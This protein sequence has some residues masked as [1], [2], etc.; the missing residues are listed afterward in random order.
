MRW[1]DSIQFGFY[2]LQIAIKTRQIKLKNSTN[3]TAKGSCGSS[4]PGVTSIKITTPNGMVIFMES[5]D[6]L[7][8]RGK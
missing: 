3:D 2:L 1:D 7:N 5:W 6:I 4:N 8:A